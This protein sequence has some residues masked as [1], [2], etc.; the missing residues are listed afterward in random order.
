MYG[1]FVI[2][3]T[4]KE[5]AELEQTTQRTIRRNIQKYQHRYV[6]C[7]GGNRGQKYEI[8][9]ESLSQTAQDRYHNIK[10][11]QEDILCYTGKQREAANYK[12]WTVVN[13]QRSGLSVNEFVLKHNEE[14]HDEPITKNK[15]FRWQKKY[16]NNQDAALIDKRGSNRKGLSSI[17]PEAWN[18]FYDIYMTQQKRTVRLCYDI[19]KLE[20]PDI[21]SVSTFERQVKKIDKRTLIYY[22][23][24]KK[25]FNDSMPYMER[26][27]IDINSNDIWFS[28]HH[29]V[30][31]FVKS[32][33]GKRIVRPWLT[34][35]FD[36][37]SNKIISHLVR[38]ADPNATA[39][40]KCFRLG[41]EAHG[42]PLE[43]YFDNGKDYRSKSFNADYPLSLVNQ[44]NIRTI[45]ATPYHGQA[46]TVERFFKTFTDRFSKRFDTY[47]GKDAKNRPE[48]MQINNDKILKL[49]PTMQ[50]Y[51]EYLTRY[52]EEYNTTKSRGRDMGGKCPEQVYCENIKVKSVFSNHKALRLLCGNSEERTV[53]KNGISLKNN[54]Y[55]NEILLKH[56]GK[57]VNIT[58]DPENID[59]ISVFDMDNISICTATAKIRTPFRHTTE[60]DYIRAGNLKKAARLGIK[61]TKTI[62]GMS[63][64]EIIA[65]NQLMEKKFSESGDI[66]ER[67]HITP[68]TALNVERLEA[69]ENSFSGRR[70][71]EEESASETLMKYYERTGG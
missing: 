28:D 14:Y 41:V 47:T 66:P 38:N 1:D 69:T 55:F 39:V 71:R 8:A 46:K 60:E 40:K 31:V 32:E 22:R 6:N 65:K 24:G 34:V 5:S 37:R 52:M 48:C 62:R 3:I 58:Y 70:I 25:A 21:P 45:Y 50:E 63:I 51:T 7:Q 18:F 57:K 11:E 42:V 49:A 33:D 16:K 35:F 2:W 61:K 56:L 15:L 29:R 59:E 67:Q 64:H 68:E 19:T 17:Q 27:K 4:T 43:V 54:S 10:R 36:A 20:Y 23:E 9:L 53:N 44:L 26:S 30:D 13:Y 12:A